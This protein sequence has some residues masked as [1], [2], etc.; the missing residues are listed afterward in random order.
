MIYVKS[1]YELAS[2]QIQALEIYTLI[3]DSQRRRK[4]IGYYLI[5]A[6]LRVSVMQNISIKY[7]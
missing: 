7:F 1:L 4:G 2:H 5:Q 3:V 6:L